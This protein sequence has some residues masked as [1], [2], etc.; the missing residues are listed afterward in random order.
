MSGDRPKIK[1]Q[2][3]MRPMLIVLLGFLAVMF[4]G[5]FFLA[6]PVS[7]TDGE[8]LN[9]N[10]AIFTSASAVC[11]TGLVV[12]STTVD[13]SALGQVIILILI[14]IGGLGVMTLA[15]LV[16]M[17]IRKRITLKDRVTLQEALGQD[18]IKGIVKLVRNIAIMTGA[19]ELTGTLLLLPFFCTKNGS[20]GIWQA[21]FTSVSAFCNAGFDIL[22]SKAAPYASLTDFKGNAGVLLIVAALITLGGLGFTVIHDIFSCRFRFKRFKLHTKIVLV[23]SL[24]LFLFGT[25]FFLGSEFRSAATAGMSGGEKLLNSIFQSVT[26]RTAGFNAIEQSDLS[27]QGRTVTCILMFIGASPGGTGG[28]IKTTTFAVL[29]LMGL[30]GLRGKNDI[31]IGMRGVKPKTAFRAVAVLLFA[32]ILILTGTVIIN[33]TDGNFS[34][35]SVLFDVMSAFSTVGLSVGVCPLLSPAAHYILIIVMFIGRLGPLSIGMMIPGSDNAGIKY[36]PANI[37]IG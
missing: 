26:A 3:R 13:F 1:K 34:T 21:I 28:G 20:I 4:V 22:G 32:G 16:F 29:L 31:L 36:P 30:S 35:T 14:Q 7:N 33:Y 18:R 10:D 9:F 11:V 15:T 23:V 25:F 37:M 6:L 12:R 17:I 19:I 2:L 5:A 24:A 27:T 8:W